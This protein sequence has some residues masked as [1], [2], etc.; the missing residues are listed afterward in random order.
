MVK[1]RGYYVPKGDGTDYWTPSIVNARAYAVR[2]IQKYPKATWWDIYTAERTK[3]RSH[4]HSMR[5]PYSSVVFYGNPE[6][7]KWFHDGKRT[8]MYANGKLRRS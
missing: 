2:M 1:E 7:Y 5:K 4:D 6:G 8:N 3:V